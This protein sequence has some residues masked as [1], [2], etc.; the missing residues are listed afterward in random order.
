MIE[1][2]DAIVGRYDLEP[3]PAEGGR[4]RQTWAGPEDATGRPAGTAI[5]ML[6]TCEPDDFSALHR[7][8]IDEVWHFYRGDVLDLLVLHP[9]G[10]AEVRH[11]GDG[12]LVQT[13]VPA[14][15]WMGARVA[16]GG[17]WSLFGTTMAPG[18]VPA[19]F[20]G[21]DPDELAR[22]YPREEELI[23]ALSRPGAPTRMRDPQGFPPSDSQ[24]TDDERRGD[25]HDGLAATPS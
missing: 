10:R 6:L 24:S 2:A 23:R 12:E 18:F 8:P 21:G 16:A 19:D 20:E 7:L 1:D 17:A 13:V 15:C 22:R 14:G 11:L 4:F 9:D 25:G 3:L 5:L